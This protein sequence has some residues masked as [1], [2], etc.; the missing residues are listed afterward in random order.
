MTQDVHLTRVADN[1]GDLVLDFCRS[2]WYLGRDF[3]AQELRDYISDRNPLA[4]PASPDRV[5]RLLRQEK[6]VDYVVISRKN[7]LYRITQLA[8]A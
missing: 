6:R 8:A 2:Q 7:S 3:H 4:A 1:I 5:L